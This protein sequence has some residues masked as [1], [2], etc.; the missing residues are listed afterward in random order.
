MKGSVVYLYTSDLY[1]MSF[2]CLRYLV[3]NIYYKFDNFIYMRG[4]EPQ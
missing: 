4:R 3:V 1:K 2:R